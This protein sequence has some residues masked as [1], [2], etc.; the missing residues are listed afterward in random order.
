MQKTE[1]KASILIWSIMLSLVISIAFIS[2]S[3]KLYKNIKL[4]NYLNSSIN[5]KNILA[6]K[7]TQSWW[8][9]EKDEFLTFE[10]NSYIINK[11]EEFD[12][13]FEWNSNFSGRITLTNWWPIVYEVK[14]YSWA[15]NSYYNITSSW[16]ITEKKANNFDWTLNNSYD[17]VNLKIKNLG[18]IS[19]VIFETN[20]DNFYWTWITKKYKIEKKIWWKYIEKTIITK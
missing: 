19:K 3:S 7:I 11:E 17:K 5:K 18:W 10:Q 4:N 2:I 15:D 1:K 13:I 16:I 9:I 14:S 6:E 20:N 12:I 8:L